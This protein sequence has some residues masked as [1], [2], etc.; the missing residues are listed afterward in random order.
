[1]LN[2]IS[3]H[4]FQSPHDQCPN[5]CDFTT[6]HSHWTFATF[7]NFLSLFPY[8]PWSLFRNS[9][10]TDYVNHASLRSYILFILNFSSRVIDFLSLSRHF[11]TASTLSHVGHFLTFKFMGCIKLG[12][13]NV[14]WDATW[15]LTAKR[16]R[17]LITAKWLWVSVSLHM[18]NNIHCSF[19]I[20]LQ[21]HRIM[22]DHV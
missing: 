3:Q 18:H 20:M 4:P 14:I 10:G 11:V 9:H 21:W 15:S 5:M 1:M 12:R 17:W 6:R 16:Q 8:G 7:F 19:K 22:W 2:A 13:Q